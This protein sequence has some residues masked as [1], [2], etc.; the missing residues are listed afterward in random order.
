MDENKEFSISEQEL[1]NIEIPDIDTVEETE[2]PQENTEEIT[3]DN[4]ETT[5]EQVVIAK[6]KFPIQVPIIISFFIVL[7]LALG[8]L[9]FKCFFNTSVCGS[10]SFDNASTSDEA[11]TLESFLIFEPDGVAAI[12]QGS[13]KM[14]GVYK[15]EQNEGVNTLTLDIPYVASTTYN[16]TITG[17]EFTG[18]ELTIS[19]PEYSESTQTL[20]SR[21]Y[22]APKLE[23]SKDFKP[24]EK[25][26][27]KWK[28]DLEFNE[29][30]EYNYIYEF[31]E[32]GTVLIN[33]ADQLFV[34]GVYTYD[35]DTITVSYYT[36]ELTEMV[37]T[38]E[39]ADDILVINS[40]IGYSRVTE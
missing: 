34:E 36:G 21:K 39:F 11:Q 19:I 32:D 8:F 14:T 38:Y 35:E 17:N 12:T 18:R 15:V 13:M 9:V 26:T 37:L 28:D 23:V 31:R 7:A 10:W 29:T 25:I 16:Y 30:F 4:E 22:T 1:E 5:S 3:T 40:Q 6:K 20:I 33:Q 27:G 24:N 2:Y